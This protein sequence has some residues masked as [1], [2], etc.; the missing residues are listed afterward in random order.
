MTDGDLGE[1]GKKTAIGIAQY[2]KAEGKA[3]G[4]MGMGESERKYF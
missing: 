3:R 4:G 1:A 2:S